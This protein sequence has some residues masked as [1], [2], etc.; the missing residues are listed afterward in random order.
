M[1]RTLRFWTLLGALAA[2]DA[3]AQGRDLANYEKILLPI[4]FQAPVPAAGGTLWSTE[5]WIRNE[6]DASVDAF[7]LSPDCISSAGCFM[8]MRPFPALAPHYTLNGGGGTSAIHPGYLGVTENPAPG[9]FVWVEKG[10][11][12]NLN[13][14]LRLVEVTMAPDSRVTRLPV[15]EQ[16]QFFETSRSIMAVH[17][18]P[19][20]RM[21]L[22]LYDLESRAGAVVRI[23][24]SEQTGHIEFEPFCCRVVTDVYVEED[25]QFEYIAPDS[26]SF[27]LGCPE[28]ALY[29]PGFVQIL[30]LFDRY[31]TLRNKVPGQGFRIEIVPITPGLRVWGFVSVTTS[32]GNGANDVAI[33]TP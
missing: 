13:V 19:P 31:P 4:Y 2:V 23:K 17:A 7:P 20:S 14:S 28:G 18:T 24:I 27:S 10:A 22:R 25:L 3:A 16:T 5:L 30:N 33:Y 9:A 12:K 29:K 26:C 21:A 8:T 32:G 6:G 15:V 1:N 11:A